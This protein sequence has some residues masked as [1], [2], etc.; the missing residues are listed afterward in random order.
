MTQ[1]IDFL[2]DKIAN[3]RYEYPPSVRRKR[4]KKAQRKMGYHRTR[5]TR[6][7]KGLLF[8]RLALLVNV[9]AARIDF[10]SHRLAR[11]SETN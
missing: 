2:D 3:I 7:V 9:L 8:I 4:V 10:F 6:V 1:D 11:A 5:R